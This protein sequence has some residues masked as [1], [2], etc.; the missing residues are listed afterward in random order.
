MIRETRQLLRL[1]TLR[2]ERAREACAQAQAAVDAAARTVHERQH[3]I[4]RAQ[5]HVDALARA[6]VH[7]LAPRLPRWADMA[8]AQRRRL[9][10]NL[11]REEYALIDD[12]HA[13]EQAQERLQRA[14]AD[15][16]RALAREDAVRGLAGEAQRAVLLMREQQ[17]ERESD[18]QP[19]R[20]AR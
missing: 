18:D 12:E 8:A 10:D 1:R 2:V 6:V 16:T 4:V 17:L 20:R 9:V 11:Q 7:D 13:L 14:R 5:R 3:A 19:A 15:L